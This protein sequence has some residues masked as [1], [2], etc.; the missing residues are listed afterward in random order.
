MGENTKRDLDIKAYYLAGGTRALTMKKW[1]MKTNQL[2]GLSTRLNMHWSWPIE[3]RRS[4]TQPLSAQWSSP[5]KSGDSGG[6]IV[7]SIKQ[8][9]SRNND[10]AAAGHE[11]PSDAPLYVAGSAPKKYGKSLSVLTRERSERGYQDSDTDF[12][13]R[14]SPFPTPSEVSNNPNDLSRAQ[15]HAI[16]SM[17]RD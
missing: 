10:S 4:G 13:G 15:I 17:Y 3:N 5:R 1:G 11:I 12:G 8:R 7:S 16:A 6:G 14:L 9:V 2:A